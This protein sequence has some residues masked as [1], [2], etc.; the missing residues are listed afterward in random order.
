MPF[1]LALAEQGVAA[2]LRSNQ[3]LANGLNVSRGALCNRE[4]GAALGL[5]V[6]SLQEALSAMA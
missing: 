5:P 1:V 3:H 2:A 6:Q 4:V